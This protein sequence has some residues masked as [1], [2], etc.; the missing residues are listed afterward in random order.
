MSTADT[1]AAWGILRAPE[2]VEL[3]AQAGLDLACA[4]VCLE[5]ESSGGR[6]V[7]G[8][9]SVD[10]GGIYRKG[11]PVIREVYA[12]YAAALQ[13]RRVGAQG[14]GPCQIT[15]P[16]LQREADDQGGCWD[17][18]TNV[19][20]G[21]RHLAA[22]QRQYGVRDGFRRYNGAGPAAEK[23]ANDAMVKL[24]RW[25]D[26]IGTTTVATVTASAVTPGGRSDAP[27]R[28]VQAAVH[29][30]VD[31]DWGPVT[32]RAVSLVRDAAR[33]WLHHITETQTAIGAHPDGLWGPQSRAALDTTVRALQRAWAVTV[34]GDWGPKTDQAWRAARAHLPEHLRTPSAA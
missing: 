2:V 24:A 22:L 9:D 1:L 33:G 20:V 19:L 25:R 15:W 34:D 5:K 10:T 32:D 7:W 16:P 28:A 11:D 6:N 21:F 3:A 23:Y 29:V 27:V 26:R 18:R 30:T 4:A 14:V 31:G 13:A 8:S 12:Q 17:W